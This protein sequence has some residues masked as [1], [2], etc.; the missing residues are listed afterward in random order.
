MMTDIINF[1]GV[2]LGLTL[3]FFGV[4]L[5]AIYMGLIIIFDIIDTI[6]SRIRPK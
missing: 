1:I 6:K 4:V 3:V 2:A 5:P